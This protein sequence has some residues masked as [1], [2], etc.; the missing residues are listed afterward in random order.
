MTYALR[1]PSF[2]R[3]KAQLS[4]NGRFNHTLYDAETR[5]AV[6]ATLDIERGAEQVSVVVRMG[7]TLNSL[8]L[9]IDAPSNANTV[10]DY[11]ESIA[12]GRLDT[13]DDTPARRRFSQA[14]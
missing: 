4:L 12:N 14:A 9:P 11:L 1:Q 3:L 7:S 6:H 2:G 8:G 10:A 13:A 5:Q